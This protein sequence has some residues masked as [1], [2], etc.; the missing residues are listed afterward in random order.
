MDVGLMKWAK[1]SVVSGQGVIDGRLA[2][3]ALSLCLGAWGGSCQLG[4]AQVGGKGGTTVD[5]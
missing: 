5:A 2:R 1:E 4:V 3:T